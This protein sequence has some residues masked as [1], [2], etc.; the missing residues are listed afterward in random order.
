MHT[1]AGAMDDDDA[2]VN[3]PKA[4]KAGL[5]KERLRQLS[6]DRANKWPNTLEVFCPPDAA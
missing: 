6:V 4:T 2:Q 5:E 3:P 1:E